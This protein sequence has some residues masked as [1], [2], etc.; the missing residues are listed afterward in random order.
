MGRIKVEMTSIPTFSECQKSR[1]PS[2]SKIIL[3]VLRKAL[4]LKEGGPLAVD[5]VKKK[6]LLRKAF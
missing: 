4:S 3:M 5:E 2:K 1:Q 6:V